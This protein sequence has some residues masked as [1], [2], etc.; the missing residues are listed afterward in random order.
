MRRTFLCFCVAIIFSV[1][2]LVTPARAFIFDTFGNGF[3]TVI[4]NGNGN[5]LVVNSSGAS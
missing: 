1:L 4:N 2:A 3:W 5:T